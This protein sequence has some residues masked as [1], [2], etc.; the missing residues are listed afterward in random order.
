MEQT[1]SKK[2]RLALLL[3]GLVVL[4]ALAIG[5]YFWWTKTQPAKYTGPV[6]KVTMGVGV[7]PLSLLIWVAEN[8]GYFA[9]NGL[10]VEIKDYPS[11]KA[12]VGDLIDD[13][14]DI[15]TITEFGFMSRSFDNPDLRIV[16][17]ITTAN[18]NTLVAIKE[19]GIEKISD[20]KGKRIATVSGTEAEFFLETFLLFNNI[21]TTDV[22]I[23]Y[24][25][26]NN[27]VQS[28]LGGEADAAMIWEPYVYQIKTNLG[29]ENTITWP[30]Q[31]G[32]SSYWLFNSKENFITRNP[33]IFKRTLKAL[34]QAEEF[35][36]TNEADAKAVLVSHGLDAQFVDDI[37]QKLNF[38]VGLSQA[39]IIAMEDGARWRVKNKLTD[40]AKI[41]N[42]L[43]YIYPDALESVKPGAVMIIR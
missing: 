20:L 31:S 42:Y 33:K 43:D 36:K 13:K 32:Q 37:W 34:V 15:A 1:G 7:A 9:D 25:N 38:I 8:E 10:D 30:G 2:A 19:K 16:S 6:E 14:V 26:S 17:S 27:I 4:A 3:G 24:I 11:G 22:E 35:V 39:L 5:G 18:I 12:A 21:P 28:V 29:E 40:K 23:I 41:P